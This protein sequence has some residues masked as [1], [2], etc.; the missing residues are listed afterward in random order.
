MIHLRFLG[1]K[2]FCRHQPRPKEPCHRPMEQET[3]CPRCRP[4]GVTTACPLSDFAPR[5]HRITE[6]SESGCIVLFYDFYPS[7][8]R[9]SFIFFGYNCKAMLVIF[10]SRYPETDGQPRSPRTGQLKS[11]HGSL[12]NGIWY[13]SRASSLVS[14]Q[15]SF[16]TLVDVRQTWQ[17][18]WAWYGVPE[19]QYVSEIG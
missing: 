12:L 13:A 7:E 17:E 10:M 16:H 8:N 15:N 9:L 1:T 5:S 11:L 19:V 3:P 14:M 18:T 2:E 6:K 4:P